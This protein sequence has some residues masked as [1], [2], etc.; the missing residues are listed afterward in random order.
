M[1]TTSSC[2]RRYSSA[3]NNYRGGECNTAPN[4]DVVT[5]RGGGGCPTYTI[6][7]NPSGGE[8]LA[9]VIS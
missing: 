5:A 3:Q 8:S 2:L 6:H 1:A 4:L 7:I 9:G